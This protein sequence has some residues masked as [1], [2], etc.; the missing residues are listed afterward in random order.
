MN[1]DGPLN[2]S[3]YTRIQFLDNEIDLC[4][5]YLDVAEVERDDLPAARHAR[6]LAEQGYA[7]AL[8][9]LSSVRAGEEWHRLMAKIINLKRRLDG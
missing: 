2:R 8:A 9:C 3:E 4:E 5:T 1:V 6:I 7:N